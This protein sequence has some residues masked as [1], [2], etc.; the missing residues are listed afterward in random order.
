MTNKDTPNKNIS[1]YNKTN[2]PKKP[3]LNEKVGFHYSS[4]LKIT[5][6]KSGEI[7]LHMRC[8]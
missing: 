8:D 4:S 2:E 7:L 6:K 5:D 3:L 1:V